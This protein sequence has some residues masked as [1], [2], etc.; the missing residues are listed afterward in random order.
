MGHFFIDVQPQPNPELTTEMQYNATFGSNRH[1]E[2]LYDVVL[3]MA[4]ALNTS[5]Y[6]ND[7]YMYQ[8]NPQA[9][10]AEVSHYMK[11]FHDRKDWTFKISFHLRNQQQVLIGTMEYSNSSITVSSFTNNN[12][13]VL[14][15]AP[16]GELP[17]F[18][19]QPPP[20]YTAILG[21]LIALMT[22]FVT[23]TLVLYVHFRKEP[24]VKA[25]SFTLSLLIYFGCYLNLLYLSLLLYAYHTLDTIDTARDNAL[26]LSLQWL[27][28]PGVPLPLMLAT[29]LVKMLRVYHIFHNSTLRRIGRHCSDLAL[30]LYVLLILLPDIFVNLIWTIF[31]PYQIHLEYRMRDGYIYLDKSCR[32][33]YKKHLFGLLS[34]YLLILIKALVVVAILTRKVRRQHF[35]DTKKVNILLF[36]LYPGIIITYCYWALLQVLHTERHISAL[37]VYIP[38]SVV[39]ILF[40]S[41]LFVPKIF[42]PL[43]QRNISKHFN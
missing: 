30:A 27:S 32:S 6:Q 7:T 26:C 10:V 24:E 23:F 19:I 16:S 35:K 4:I 2:L 25:T 43:W 5:I 28:G 31:D 40:Q 12:S 14:E 29:L 17:V 39:I 9:T 22:I 20:A 21:L 42:P 8:A 41:L 13:Y 38:H 33:T 36:I 37:S 1:A 15:N 18:V 3:A 11:S 34:T